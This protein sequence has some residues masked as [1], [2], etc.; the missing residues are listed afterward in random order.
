MIYINNP[1]FR[2]R[3]FIFQYD[4]IYTQ[5]LNIWKHHTKKMLSIKGR[6]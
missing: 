1:R 5:Q 2:R 6:E 3:L 4:T